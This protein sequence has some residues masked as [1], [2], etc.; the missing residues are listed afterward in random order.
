MRI[1]LG[2]IVGVL[3]VSTLSA[4]AAENPTLLEKARQ[5]YLS[6]QHL[7]AEINEKASANRTRPE[8]L[9][10][11]NAYQRVYLIT[12]HTS[13]A[14]DALMAMA[15]LYEEIK[16][17]SAATRTLRYLLQ[18]YPGTP[19][20]TA[21]ERDLAR[22][23]T[24]PD[25]RNAAA[26][27]ESPP[28]PPV[29]DIP[30]A[31]RMVSADNVQKTA[32]VESVQLWDAPNSV[33]IVI[34][35][36]G[37]VAYSQGD[38]KSPKRFFVNLSPAKLDSTLAGKQWKS[39]SGLLEQIRVGQYDPSTVRVVLEVGAIGSITTFTLKEPDRLIIDVLGK[40]P[41][42]PPA[43]ASVTP[44]TS[45]PLAKPAVRPASAPALPSAPV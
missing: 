13:F 38:A 21:A 12:P 8:Y 37:E 18:N 16:D 9:K 26:K 33:R 24:K 4:L 10:L 36:T 1:A 6:A 3:S 39:K 22:L 34:G 2:F 19:L 43:V 40:E 42:Q 25:A 44:P 7:E 20:K 32:S 35:L 45:P 11:I 31:S 28:K 27:I 29:A 23:T 5:A 14:D 41:A 15:R 17:N 30:P